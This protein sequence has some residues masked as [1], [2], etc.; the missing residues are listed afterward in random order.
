VVEG[1]PDDL[2]AAPGDTSPSLTL[3]TEK[4]LLISRILLTFPEAAVYRYTVDVSDDRQLWRPVANLGTNTDRQNSRE[5]SPAQGTSGRY[6]RVTFTDAATAALAE[7][8]V[9]GMIAD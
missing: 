4:G 7:I 9:T 8:R 1:A 3:D 5:F 6:V 2:A